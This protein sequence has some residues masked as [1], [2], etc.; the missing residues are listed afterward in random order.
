MLKAFGRGWERTC[1]LKE[2]IIMAID[3]PSSGLVVGQIFVAPN[4]V[5]YQWDGT[6]WKAVSMTGGGFADF[7]AS[8]NATFSLPASTAT[9]LTFNTVVTGNS[10]G[11]YS[12]STGRFT[13][14]AGRYF[15]TAGM[16]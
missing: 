13:P 4:G 3:F 5:S 2:K 6:L 1:S 14:P 9:T 10:G 12:T 11:W 7:F 8:H 15:L 16:S